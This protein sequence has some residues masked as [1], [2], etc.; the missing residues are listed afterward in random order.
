MA[1]YTSLLAFMEKL[2]ELAGD[3]PENIK[4]KE[5]TQ[6][7]QRSRAIPKVRRKQRDNRFSRSR[8][9]RDQS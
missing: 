9:G 4:M 3:D 1:K 7:V 2:K 6:Y 8:S 5:G